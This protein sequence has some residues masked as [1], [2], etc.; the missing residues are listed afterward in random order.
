[1]PVGQHA[2]RIGQRRPHEREMVGQHQVIVRGEGDQFAPCLAQRDVAVGIAEP[3][4]LRQVKEPDARIG[5]PGDNGPRVVRNPVAD[6]QQFEIRHRLSQ[7]RRDGI[8]DDVGP[9]MGRHQDGE[10]RRVH[11]PLAFP[12]LYGMC[13][14]SIGSR[15]LSGFR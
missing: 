2:A 13:G 6:D 14:V 5:E 12:K 3:R 10:T 7:H 4:A 1:L 15:Y 11:H 9:G 8:S